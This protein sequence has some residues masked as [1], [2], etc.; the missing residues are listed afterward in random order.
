MSAY[1]YPR[2]V[3]VLDEKEVLTDGEIAAQVILSRE[4]GKGERLARLEAISLAN[5]KREEGASLTDV[6]HV[7]RIADEIESERQAMAAVP[8]Q[9][10]AVYIEEISKVGRLLDPVKWIVGMRAKLGVSEIVAL[11]LMEL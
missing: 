5:G 1:I 4:E 2:A 3:N 10:E 11:E 7:N 8:I 9:A 6:L